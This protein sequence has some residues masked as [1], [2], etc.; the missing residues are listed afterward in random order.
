MVIYNFRPSGRE[1]ER[2]KGKDFKPKFHFSLSYLRRPKADLF[3][4]RIEKPNESWGVFML[5][6]LTHVHLR[7]LGGLEV[8]KKRDDFKNTIRE[9]SLGTSKAAA[10]RL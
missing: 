7:G 5:P 2:Q 6:E 10:D 8:T 9:Q 3:T 1:V 4:F